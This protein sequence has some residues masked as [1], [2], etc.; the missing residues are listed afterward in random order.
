[1]IKPDSIINYGDMLHVLGIIDEKDR[2]YVN[3][4]C[5]LDLSLVKRGNL[6]MA[7][8][9]GNTVLAKGRKGQAG[10]YASRKSWCVSSMFVYVL[11]GRK[12]RRFSARDSEKVLVLVLCG[13]QV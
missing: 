2:Q 13:I 7:H 4:Q 3:E 5:E 6:H 1:M 9:V 12:V 8:R 10:E 11:L